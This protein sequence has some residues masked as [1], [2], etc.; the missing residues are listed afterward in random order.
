MFSIFKRD[1]TKKLEKRRSLLLEQAMQAQRSG[2][3]RTYSKLT[4]EA[5]EVFK[6]IQAMKD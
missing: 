4:A 1:P 5:E 2:D 3:I 6:T